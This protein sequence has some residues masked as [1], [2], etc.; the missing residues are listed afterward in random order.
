MKDDILSPGKI[1]WQKHS[2]SEIV[3]S[4]KHNYLNL[5]L[6]EKLKNGGHNVFIEDDS[7]TIVYSE[8]VELFKQMKNSLQLKE[9]LPRR[10]KFIILLLNNYINSQ[11]SQDDLNQLAWRLFSQM[12]RD[13]AEEF[14]NRDMSYFKRAMSV[15]GS[16]VFCAFLIGHYEVPFLTTLYNSTFR[17]LMT[18]GKEETVGQLKNKLEDLRQKSHLDAEDQ[19]FIETITT[20]ENVNQMILLEKFDGSGLMGFENQDLT[21]LEMILC[22]LNYYFHWDKEYEGINIL[23]DISAGKFP[24]NVKLVKLIKAN[25]EIA[26]KENELAA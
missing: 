8:F 14:L 2:G 19:K 3:I 17:N 16:F 10:N 20:Q 18:I 26:R 15:T 4:T 22:S 7:E 1:I 5:K 13:E 6:I 21:D 23:A 25:V 9:T 24:I 11:K 12:E